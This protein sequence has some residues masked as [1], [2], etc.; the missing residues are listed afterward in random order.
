MPLYR[1]Q[2]FR[3]Q[4]FAQLQLAQTEDDLRAAV[5]LNSRLIA[6]FPDEPLLPDVLARSYSRLGVKLNA[7]GRTTEAIDAYQHGAERF[8]ELYIRLHHIESAS[9]ES[10]ERW[11]I[12]IAQ[13]KLGQRSE[14]Q[15]SMGQAVAILEQVAAKRPNEPRIVNSLA[16]AYAFMAAMLDEQ[17]SAPRSN[18]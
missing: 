14:A 9:E 2:W 15:M 16:H 12:G 18:S 1:R 6:R 5:A 3:L 13:R 10:T 17:G 11:N 4:S 8:H 7:A